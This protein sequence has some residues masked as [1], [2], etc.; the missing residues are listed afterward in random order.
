MQVFR[1]V[2]NA[3]KSMFIETDLLSIVH[4]PCVVVNKS[5][6]KMNSCSLK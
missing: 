5:Q 4:R 3:N 2:K 1:N 6:R